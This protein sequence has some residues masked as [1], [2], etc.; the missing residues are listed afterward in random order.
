MHRR[1]RSPPSSKFIYILPPGTKTRKKVDEKRQSRDIEQ[2]LEE[3]DNKRSAKKKK[4]YS[5][6]RPFLM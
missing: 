2:S 6:Q 1:K 3:T 4:G 5:H